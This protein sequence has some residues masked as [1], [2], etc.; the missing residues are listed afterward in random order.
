MFRIG[1]MSRL[2]LL[3]NYHMNN[4]Y[5]QEGRQGGKQT[6]NIHCRI[7]AQTQFQHSGRKEAGNG[8]NLGLEEQIRE[9]ARSAANRKR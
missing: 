6:D 1:I 2:Q 7:F 4:N 3:N 5:R 8:S 9:C